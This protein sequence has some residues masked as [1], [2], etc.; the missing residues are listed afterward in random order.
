MGELLKNKKASFKKYFWGS[1]KLPQAHRKVCDENE[2]N[3]QRKNDKHKNVFDGRRHF[4]GSIQ[5]TGED[6]LDNHWV[7]DS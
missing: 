1:H 4:I 7:N 2:T 6:S 5:E 3:K